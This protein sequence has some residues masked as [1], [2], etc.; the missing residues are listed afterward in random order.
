MKSLINISVMLM[1][2]ITMLVAM[3]GAY[4]IAGPFGSLGIVIMAALAV[5]LGSRVDD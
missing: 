4:T 2:A 5:E 3:H 1:V